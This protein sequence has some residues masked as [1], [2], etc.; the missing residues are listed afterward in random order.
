MGMTLTGTV[1]NGGAYEIKG[2]DGSTRVMISFN[3]AD[4]LGNTFS[5]QMW[6]DNPQH[7]ELAGIIAQMR[8][9]PVSLAVVGYT[10]RMREF[11]DGRQPAPQ[12][13]FIVSNVQF[14]N[15]QQNGVAPA[16]GAA[17]VGR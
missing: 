12:A 15:Y 9:Q 3:V 16:A 5:C 4:E 13:N 11:K 7:A 1:K 6:P 8:Y 17:P 14:P 2:K 10:A